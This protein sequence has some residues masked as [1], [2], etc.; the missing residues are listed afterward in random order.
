L[1]VLG[2]SFP[3]PSGLLSFLPEFLEPFR[4]L[5]FI[6]IYFFF[7]LPKILRTKL[8]PIDPVLGV[9]KDIIHTQSQC[10]LKEKV[11]DKT[12]EEL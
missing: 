6:L 9:D 7:T 4:R 5:S 1:C 10:N 2:L 3:I 11:P 8:E 12:Q